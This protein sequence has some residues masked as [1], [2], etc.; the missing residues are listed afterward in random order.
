MFEE[1]NNLN[2]EALEVSKLKVILQTIRKNLMKQSELCSKFNLTTGCI[3][4]C[5]KQISN[6][7]MIKQLGYMV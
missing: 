2:N 7:G 5:I 4:K 6:T 3:Y 1:F